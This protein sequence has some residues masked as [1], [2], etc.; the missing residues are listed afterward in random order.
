MFG[1]FVVR[2]PYGKALYERE[3]F[4]LGDDVGVLDGK[5]EETRA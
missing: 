5:I 3:Y 1:R 4:V 2:G